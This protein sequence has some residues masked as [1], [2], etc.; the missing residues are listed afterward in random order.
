MGCLRQN[1]FCEPYQAYEDAD[2]LHDICESYWIQSSYYRVEDSN[3]RG[4]DN[5]YGVI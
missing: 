5:S 1:F 4:N 2:E 3:T